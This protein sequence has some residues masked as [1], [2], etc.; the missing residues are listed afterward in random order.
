[1]RPPPEPC[2]PL[3]VR[4]VSPDPNVTYSSAG[5]PWVQRMN[6]EVAW[7]SE[8]DQVPIDQLLTPISIG[9]PI[10]WF[11][12]DIPI[13]IGYQLHMCFFPNH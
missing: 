1:M 10:V 5:R 11:F 13:D 8:I 2:K 9:I 6:V 12:L 7:I 3:A 4:K